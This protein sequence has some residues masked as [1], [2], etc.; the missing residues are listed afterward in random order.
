MVQ[1]LSAEM[2]VDT[3]LFDFCRLGMTAAGTNGEK[4]LA[5][6]R[7]RVLTNSRHIPRLLERARCSGDHEHVVLQGGRAAG[8]QV[9]TESFCAAIVEGLKREIADE[10]WV[11]NVYDALTRLR[12]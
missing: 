2:G 6:K 4:G 10:Q 5:K 3:V 7:T 11:K 8:C 9:Y 1:R 12:R